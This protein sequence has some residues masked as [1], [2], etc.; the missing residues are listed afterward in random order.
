MTTWKLFVRL[1]VQLILWVG[2]VAF[3]L[4][5]ITLVVGWLAW[6]VRWVWAQN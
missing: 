5:G 6:V 4:A 3:F 1:V 2:A